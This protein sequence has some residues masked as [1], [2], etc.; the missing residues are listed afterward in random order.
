MLCGRFVLGAAIGLIGAAAALAGP[1]VITSGIGPDAGGEG[2]IKHGTLNGV[3]AYSVATVACNIGNQPASWVY[4]NNRHPVI[5]SQMYRLL[6]GRFEQIGMSW[7][8]HSFCA[9]DQPP[10]CVGLVPGAVYQGDNFCD[11]LGP[12]AAD[13]YNAFLNGQQSNL[14]PRSEVNASTGNFP[15]PPAMGWGNSNSFN[16][17]TKRLQVANADLDPADNAGARY[18]V[19]TVH[20]T[21]DEAPA[22]R[23]NNTSYREIVVGPLTSGE[24]GENGCSPS[25][26]GYALSFIGATTVMQPVIEAWRAADPSVTIV[27]ADIAGDGR[28]GVASKVTDLG[29]G[30]WQY[31]YAVH[32]INS[33]RSV[34][35]FSIPKAT[36]PGVSISS[37]GFRDVPYHSGEPLDGTDWPGA[38][39]DDNITWA[40]TPWTVNPNANAIRWSTTYNFRFRANRA[41]V[42][43]T[44][45]LGLFK[46]SSP[47]SITLSGLPTPGG[48]FSC[49]AD[50]DGSGG[51][52]TVQD[53]FDFVDAYFTVNPA[54]D[55]NRDGSVT[56]Q[57]IFEFLTAYFTPCP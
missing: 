36:G 10:G 48:A 2:I 31:E 16:C 44:V 1:D 13:V 17:L 37:L 34:G 35:S 20:I 53:I 54:A 11:T 25:A 22:A 33:D 14:G 50:F 45:T 28:V 30:L 43:G 40:T 21:V 52:P 5:G 38:V 4:F 57:D 29:A 3:T 47:G 9:A 27:Y 23:L 24:I 56:L 41:P 6:N 15:Y 19:E 51:A 55:F 49:P 46:G 12:F 8:K 39:N 7:L 26:Q 18:F 32:N 42:P